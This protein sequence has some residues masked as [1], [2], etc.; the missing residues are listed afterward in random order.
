M[1]TCNMTPHARI[2][3]NIHR[4]VSRGLSGNRSHL[5]KILS[6]IYEKW[7]N[8]WEMVFFYLSFP[9]NCISTND[10]PLSWP[11]LQSPVFTQ[12]FTPWT[13]GQS[14]TERTTW[15]SGQSF[16]QFTPWTP[17]LGLVFTQLK[18]WIPGQTPVRQQLSSCQFKVF[19]GMGSGRCQV[20]TFLD[21][22]WNIAQASPCQAS[23]IFTQNRL[24]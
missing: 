5:P 16:T 1:W 21:I 19:T 3:R 17:G 13:P 4:D 7:L 24:R 11:K 18:A 20:F 10:K 23:S 2:L 12:L 6:S 22:C 15:T 14:F 9:D 8:L